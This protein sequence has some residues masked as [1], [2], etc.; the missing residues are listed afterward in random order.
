[1]DGHLAPEVDQEQT[2]GR[3]IGNDNQGNHKQGKKRQ[4]RP[5]KCY[6]RFVKTVAGEKEIQA[7]RGSAVTNLQIGQENNAK[8]DQVN[9]I[10]FCNGD[11]ERYY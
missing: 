1:M 11:Y 5:V 3:E 4:G 6:N 9:I 8:M 2:Y 7:N 10:C